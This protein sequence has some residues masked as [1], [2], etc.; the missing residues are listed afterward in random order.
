MAQLSDQQATDLVIKEVQK[1]HPG[2]DITSSTSFED[3]LGEDSIAK[4][5]YWG[6]IR[7]VLPSGCT[8][9]GNPGDTDSC[10]TVQDLIDLTKKNT[11]CP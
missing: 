3:D 9:S 10:S 8:L 6:A 4:R 7:N 5:K 11:S 1:Y 2:H